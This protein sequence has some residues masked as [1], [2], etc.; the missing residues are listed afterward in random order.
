MPQ[1]DDD[2]YHLPI[3]LDSRFLKSRKQLKVLE[4]EFKRN[5]CWNKEKIRL[6]SKKLRLKEC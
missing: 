6:L 5:P 4:K 1:E 3:E 2:T